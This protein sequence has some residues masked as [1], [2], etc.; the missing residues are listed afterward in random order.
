MELELK[1]KIWALPIVTIVVLL[2][3]LGV[4]LRVSTTTSKLLV[5]LRMVDSPFLAQS[6]AL[7]FNQKAV[8][9]SLTSAVA[10]GD[11][12]ALEQAAKSAEAFKKELA[13]LRA[14]AGKSDLGVKMGREFDAYYSAAESAAAIMLGLRSGDVASAVQAMQ[15]AQQALNASLERTLGIAVEGLEANLLSSEVNL[16]RG[17]M[18]NLVSAA[19]VILVIVLVSRAVVVSVLKQLGGDPVYAVSIVHRVA[20]GDLGT[21]INTQAVDS[22]SLVSAM[23]SMQEK[24]S[25]LVAGIRDSTARVS[26][27][28][29]AMAA[30]NSRLSQR[31]QEQAASLEETAA[32]MEELTSTVKLNADNARCANTLAKTASDVASRGSLAMGGVMQ[33]MASIHDSSRKIGDI[34]GVID[35]IAFQ[36]NILALNAAVEAARAGEQG[37]GFAVVAAEVRSLAQRSASAAKDIKMLISASVE[38]IENGSDQVN[39]ASATMAEISDSVQKVA[40]IIQ[41]IAGASTEQSI[42]IEQINQAVSH[43]DRLTQQNTT[44]VEE[45]TAATGSLEQL[46]GELDHSI[47]LFRLS[48]EKAPGAD[49]PAGFGAESSSRKERTSPR[50][51]YLLQTSPTISS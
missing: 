27:T 9:E 46:A 22:N 48:A 10:T 43:L 37:R 35:G 30:S 40:Q 42:G 12:K 44:L 16:R 14:L 23:K 39:V 51:A 2:V 45:A 18:V 7:A 28:A 29:Q 6:Q 24:L 32:S 3:G 50:A 49:R 26:S 31:T 38:R 34:I 5:D 25:G 1:K 19:T 11:K 33:T 21:P 17:L 20:T 8:Q 13:T 15:T 36:T 47:S 41:Q 4:N